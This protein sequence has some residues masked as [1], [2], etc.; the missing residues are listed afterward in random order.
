LCGV[1]K[2]RLQ[3]WQRKYLIADG[4]MLQGRF[5]GKSATVIL[6]ALL[7]DP[8]T[9]QGIAMILA[10]DPDFYYSLRARIFLFN[11]Y[12]RHRKTC[13]AV[14]LMSYTLNGEDLRQLLTKERR[15]NEI[16][17]RDW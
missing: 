11:E 3:R 15:L 13:E 10:K 5:V 2:I 6:E 17:F 9:L 8:P 16:H 1:L 4:P 14:G 12:M 7:R